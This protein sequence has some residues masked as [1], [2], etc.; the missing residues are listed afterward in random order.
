MTY[1]QLIAQLRKRV[2]KAGGVRAFG[3]EIGISATYVSFALN[4]R[5]T[6]LG[7]KFLKRAGYEAV[8]K[9][10]MQRVPV[11]TGERVYRKLKRQS[12]AAW[13]GNQSEY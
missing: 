2:A 11:P 9:T 3:R 8:D 7:V 6:N 1:E 5:V 12:A 13:A 10:K 4:G